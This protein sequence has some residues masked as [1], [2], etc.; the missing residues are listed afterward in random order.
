MGYAVSF[1]LDL[2]T[3]SSSIALTRTCVAT[4]LDD[5]GTDQIYS[6][7][8][9]LLLDTKNR[10]RIGIGWT[11]YRIGVTWTSAETFGSVQ[12]CES[13]IQVR[14]L[15]S[16]TNIMTKYYLSKENDETI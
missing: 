4:I 14:I 2:D 5:K 8:L 6:F 11:R 3:F 1:D 15:S 7:P 16:S 10:C 13:F 12:K 9:H